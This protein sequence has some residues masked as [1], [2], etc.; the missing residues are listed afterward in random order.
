MDS[1]KAGAPADTMVASIVGL[2]GEATSRQPRATA[3]A[4]LVIFL[5]KVSLL[6]VYMLAYLGK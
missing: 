4:Q 1:R 3:R 6:C 5:W 2:S